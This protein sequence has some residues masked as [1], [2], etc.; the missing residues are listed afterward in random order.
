[1]SPIYIAIFRLKPFAYIK[2]RY[3]DLSTDIHFGN[4]WWI[5]KKLIGGAMFFQHKIICEKK[6]DSYINTQ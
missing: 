3:D 4:I 5:I 6:S 2:T 1:M